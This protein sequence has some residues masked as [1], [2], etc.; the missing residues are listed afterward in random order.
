[1][2]KGMK[3]NEEQEE[4]NKINTKNILF[5][6]TARPIPFHTHYKISHLEKTEDECL[7]TDADRIQS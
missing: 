5:S 4:K 2:G 3:E 6:F 7:A 1:M